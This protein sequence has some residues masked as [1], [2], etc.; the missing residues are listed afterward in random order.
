MK[1]ALVVY[2]SMFGNTGLVA[3]AVAEGLR[4]GMTV[5]LVEVG[6]APPVLGEEVELLVVGGPT[7]AFSMSKPGTRADAARQGADARAAAGAGLRE[8]VDQVGK[9]TA[10]P[11][12]VAFD[13]KVKRPRLPGSAA[14]AA[15]TRLRRAGFRT[16]KPAENFYV[17]GTKGPLV[18]GELD[19]ARNW[20]ATC[21]AE[22]A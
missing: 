15:L 12:V 18:D 2:E 9:G 22:M 8:W 6:S 7:H 21:A 19:R 1:R 17:G 11:V 3:E 4:T 20:G 13:T 16:V 5:D 14:R 10:R